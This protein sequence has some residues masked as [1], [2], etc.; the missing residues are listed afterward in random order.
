MH[1]EKIIPLHFSPSYNTVLFGSTI[2]LFLLLS[3]SL[4]Q[5]GI[6]QVVQVI[7]TGSGL[8]L[9]FLGCGFLFFRSR[10]ESLRITIGCLIVTIRQN[11]SP[12]S[13]R[14]LEG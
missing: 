4:C 5:T 8:F 1:N 12:E 6:Q 13:E 11:K 3:F 14:R 10:L 2:H 9:L 7:R